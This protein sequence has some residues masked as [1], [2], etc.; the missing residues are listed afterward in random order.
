VPSALCALAWA[1]ASPAG[2]AT[3]TAARGA[4]RGPK[5]VF[6]PWR[7]ALSQLPRWLTDVL[8][9]D[10]DRWLLWASLALLALAMGLGV[11][12]A[13][14]VKRH[15][16]DALG[17]SLGLRL[18]LLAPTCAVAYFVSPTGYDWIWPIAPRFPLLAVVFAV[19]LVAPLPRPAA[20]ALA[21]C[22]AIV[23]A[24][25]FHFVGSAFAAFQREE[26]GAFDDALEAIPPK[27]RVVGLIFDRGSRHVAFSPFIHYVAYY[28][29][30]RGGAVMFT[31]ADFPQSPFSFREADRPPRVP[32][33]WEWLPQRVRLPDLAWYE[34]VLVRG[35]PGRIARARD[36]YVP[37]HRSARWSVWKR[38]RESTDAERPRTR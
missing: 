14:I 20:T 31:F 15:R 32:P 28:Q 1:A 37:L 30:Q 25:H 27:S 34:Y 21:V 35:G 17:R 33:R 18:M 11:V 12:T 2:R 13:A 8:A 19:L 4:D 36:H 7:S 23:S 38:T 3:V 9:G 26:V 10:A 29:A 24:A 6:E 22:A 5:P 16:L